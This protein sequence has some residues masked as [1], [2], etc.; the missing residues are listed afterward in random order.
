MFSPIAA[1]SNFLI[2]PS[3][4]NRVFLIVFEAVFDIDLRTVSSFLGRLK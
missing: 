4:L 3:H 2:I 1:S